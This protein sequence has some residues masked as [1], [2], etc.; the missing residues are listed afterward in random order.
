MK[1]VTAV[2]PYLYN[3]GCNFK[4]KPWQ[5]W[6]NI[7]GDVIR[8][9]YPRILH[10]IL[11]SCDCLPS[12]YVKRDEAR[13]CFS[14]PVSLFFDT[15]QSALF[16]E[17]IPFL[18]DCWEEYDDILC[19]WLIRH[20]IKTCIFTSEISR[21]RILERIPSLETF[22]VTEGISISEY[23][24]GLNLVDRELDYYSFGRIPENIRNLDY[25]GLKTNS[26]GSDEYLAWALQNSKATI[27]VPRCDVV[28]GCHET[29]TQRY[30]ECMLSRM[31]M[32]GR[33]PKE[34]IELIGYD[35]VIP[36]D[37]DNYS[38]QIKNIVDHIEDYQKI[39]DKNREVALRMAPWEIRMKQVMDW[40]KSIGYTV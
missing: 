34:L 1:R 2:E 14:T 19:K 30:W 17:I 5:A 36:I 9:K 37:Y 10:K 12:I 39:V 8:G 31:V 33:A 16:Y 28:Q 22:V 23:S 21:L 40:L 24:E 7:G 15:W 6:T 26:N 32:V 18:W 38:E 27:A 29:L 11:F 25:K 4:H 35:P 3:G 20:K 13:I